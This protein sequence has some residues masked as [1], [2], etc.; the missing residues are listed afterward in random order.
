MLPSPSRRL[1]LLPSRL[2]VAHGVRQ[3]QRAHRG[4]S[5]RQRAAQLRCSPV[6]AEAT[7]LSLPKH[8]QQL[9]D[10][11]DPLHLHRPH[12]G[13]PSTSAIAVAATATVAGRR[14]MFAAIAGEACHH[15]CAG[16]LLLLFR[17]LFNVTFSVFT[18]TPHPF[19]P[20]QPVCVKALQPRGVH[21]HIAP[22]YFLA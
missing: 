13:S 19:L 20:T 8:L 21:R 7:R 14:A 1:P 15:L 3:L 5:Q 4:M 11:S 17:V 6:C 10:A 18:C 12:R 22:H 16:K 2:G 9:G